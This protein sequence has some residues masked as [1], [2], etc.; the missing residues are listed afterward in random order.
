MTWNSLHP[1]QEMLAAFGLGLL[2]S[3]DRA[4]IETHVSGCDT[5]CEFLQ[6]LPADTLISLLTPAASAPT[7]AEQGGQP[8]AKAP[9]PLPPEAV[10]DTCPEPFSGRGANAVGVPATT[11]WPAGLEVPEELAGH[12]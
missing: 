11:S 8:P 4:A 6:S 1:E 5:C 10:P 3:E 12:P 7:Q 9:T 2:R